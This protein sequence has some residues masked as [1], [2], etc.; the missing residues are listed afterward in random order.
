MDNQS[1][2]GSLLERTG[3]MR[4]I[5]FLSLTITLAL[6]MLVL[7]Q[8]VPPT[9]PL[10]Y[11]ERE[12][13]LDDDFYLIE[14]RTR[15]EH[16][17]LQGN[18]YGVCK[19]I[20]D[21]PDSEVALREAVKASECL[22]AEGIVRIPRTAAG[23]KLLHKFKFR[24]MEC[25]NVSADADMHLGPFWGSYRDAASKQLMT[26]IVTMQHDMVTIQRESR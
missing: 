8:L 10:T 6:F 5:T 23:F 17:V 24:L 9:Y 20:L 19:Q 14:A 4:N 22:G 18:F 1:H 26:D 25:R 12:V 11:A 7:S 16:H 2:G 13:T 15:V 3:I 21:D